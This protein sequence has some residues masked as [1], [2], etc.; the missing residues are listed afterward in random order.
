MNKNITVEGYNFNYRAIG[1]YRD[2]TLL[3]LHG[4]L[5]ECNEFNEAISLLS[6]QFYCLSV[7]LPGHGQTQVFGG[8]EY[9]TIE[10][11]AKGLISFLQALNINQ[12]A[13]VGYSM[14]GRLALY[15]ALHFPK[16]FSKII[17][18][19]TSCGLKT[20][21]ERN[22]RIDHDFNLA[23]KLE[24][25]SFLLFLTRWYEQPLFVSLKK[26]PDFERMLE[27]RLQ[28]NPLELAKSLRNLSTGCQ[29]SLWGKIRENLIPWLL[30]VG[31][32]DPKFIS[33]NAEIASLCDFAQ[34]EIVS[35]CGHNIHLENVS[36]F[37]EKTKIF[38]VED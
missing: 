32:L 30:F 13:L 21:A 10:K 14:G 6:D 9:Y 7:D 2:F 38:L 12:C 15:L 33:I 1:N 23:K 31:E 4:F 25:E 3:F 27:S 35:N 37:V 17:L 20:Q 18:E 11:T 22:Q 8:E 34:L 36:C 26:H 24:T 29:P 5:G 16:Y 19:S 28:S